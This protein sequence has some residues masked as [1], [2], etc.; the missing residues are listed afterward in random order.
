MTMPIGGL[1]VTDNRDQRDIQV[2]ASY[3]VLIDVLTVLG[4]YVDQMVIVGG[5][6]PELAYPKSG[7]IG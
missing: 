1:L 6:V 2:D 7:H 5:W 3:C 4:A